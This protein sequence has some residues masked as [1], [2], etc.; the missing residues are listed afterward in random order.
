[1]ATPR[2]Q[3]SHD[4]QPDLDHLCLRD[5]T[6][7]PS[8]RRS[9]HDEA[10]W[11]TPM[12]TSPPNAL[13]RDF[14]C[15]RCRTSTVPS[16]RRT[17]RDTGARHARIAHMV[18]S[19]HALLT[20]TSPA[21]PTTELV[22]TERALGRAHP[23]WHTISLSIHRGHPLSSPAWSRTR[24]RTRCW[25]ATAAGSALVR[26]ARGVVHLDVHGQCHCQAH[27][28]TEQRATTGAGQQKEEK[29]EPRSCYVNEGH[30]NR[31]PAKGGHGRRGPCLAV[32]T[33]ALLHL[34]YK[35]EAGTGC[36]CAL[37]G[38]LLRRCR[39]MQRRR[40]ART[41]SCSRRWAI[42]PDDLPVDYSHWHLDS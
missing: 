37:F 4:Q 38:P 40:A 35:A 13:G 24:R 9:Q 12:E 2:P 34:L 22:M 36:W 33:K 21:G 1:M 32:Q 41:S 27:A 14:V 10:A 6:A 26:H 39:G 15:A 18:Y 5:V 28:N 3:H 30:V 7:G 19:S 25:P 17:L 29:N 16:M 23:V 20:W 8:A 42:V 31:L 11:S